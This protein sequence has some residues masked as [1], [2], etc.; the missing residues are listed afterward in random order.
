MVYAVNNMQRYRHFGALQNVNIKATFYRAKTG[1]SKTGNLGEKWA[2]WPE[3][4][5][6]RFLAILWL[7]IEGAR[8]TG[9]I[10]KK[11]DFITWFFFRRQFFFKK[12]HNGAKTL[13]IYMY[14]YI[15]STCAYMYIGSMHVRS[16]YITYGSS[17]LLGVCVSFYLIYTV[18]SRTI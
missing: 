16:T 9:K 1:R 10:D 18:H 11:R 4:G 5:T 2:K 12:K 7:F 15:C 6:F 3:F 17:V 13:H 14:I 8:K